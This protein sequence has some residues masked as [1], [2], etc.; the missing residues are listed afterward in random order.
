MQYVLFVTAVCSWWGRLKSRFLRGR[1]TL[2]SSTLVCISY[3]RRKMT[4][5]NVLEVIFVATGLAG[6]GA[7][8]W[9]AAL[10]LCGILGVVACERSAQRAADRARLD[11]VEQHILRKVA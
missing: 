7:I 6:I 1:A 10:I 4:D 2:K 3:S 9:P 5:P 11:A 8:F